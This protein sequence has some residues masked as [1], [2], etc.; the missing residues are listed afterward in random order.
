[1][2]A[3]HEPLPLC[4]FSR[5]QQCA[6]RRRR[7]RRRR[8]TLLQ[9]RAA[10]GGPG[11]EGVAGRWPRS[12]RA[13]RGREERRREPPRRS[14]RDGARET[15][16]AAAR[17][18][19]R[20]DQWTCAGVPRHHG[21]LLATSRNKMATASRKLA[22]RWTHCLHSLFPCTPH[23]HLTDIMCSHFIHRTRHLHIKDSHPLITE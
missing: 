23:S 21:D 2:L 9:Y 14:E 10:G 5:V 3:R 8:H 7:R 4:L 19:R 22:A 18:P 6:A 12:R 1:M 16:A 13:A 17:L 15:P 20:R 11:A